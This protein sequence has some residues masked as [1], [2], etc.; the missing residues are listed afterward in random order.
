MMIGMMMRPVMVITLAEIH[1]P[2][3]EF[4][5]FIPNVQWWCQGV[6][7][8][9]NT[10]NFKVGGNRGVLMIACVVDGTPGLGVRTFHKRD[11][12]MALVGYGGVF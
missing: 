4:V 12:Y 10:P 3:S 5:P 11:P 8:S 9:G 6:L 7:H 1:K 2:Y